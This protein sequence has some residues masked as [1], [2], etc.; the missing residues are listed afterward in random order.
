[1]PSIVSAP[2]AAAVASTSI[3]SS[4]T[5]TIVAILALLLMASGALVAKAAETSAILA[6]ATQMARVAAKALL[7]R[8][9][10]TS[11]ARGVLRS[12]SG[13][14]LLSTQ[15]RRAW[16]AILGIT[17]RLQGVLAGSWLTT[18]LLGIGTLTRV[19]LLAS[20]RVGKTTESAST[21]SCT[22]VLRSSR[23]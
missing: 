3:T 7:V 22:M 21:C 13:S 9:L 15:S 10:R 19:T 4:E 6:V 8:L 17:K 16:S 14:A 11:L 23:R 2:A 18:L 1:M 12:R 5:A 20:E